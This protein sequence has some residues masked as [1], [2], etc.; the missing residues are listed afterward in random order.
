ME[1]VIFT[2][3]DIFHV[4]NTSFLNFKTH[5]TSLGN[6]KSARRIIKLDFLKEH[7][8]VF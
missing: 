8:G 6:Q 7:R 5:D 3:F 1:T 4:V 2:F